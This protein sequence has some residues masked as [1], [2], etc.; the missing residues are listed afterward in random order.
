MRVDVVVVDRDGRPVTGLSAFDFDVSDEGRPREIVSFEPIVV[1]TPARPGQTEVATRFSQPMVPLIEGNR[2]FLIFFDDVHVH[3]ENTEPVRAQLTRFL[4][5]ETREGDWVTLMSPLA[6]LRFTARTAFE[7]SRLPVVISS[8]KGQLVRPVLGGPSDYSAMRTVEYGSPGELA[9][10]AE[11]GRYSTY[12]PSQSLLAAEAYGVAR[13]RIRRSLAGLSDAI[14]SL[15][16][17]RGRKSVLLYSEGFIKSPSMPDYD[18]VIDLARRT[19]VAIYYVDPRGVGRETIPSELDTASGGTTYLATATGGRVSASNDFAAPMRAAAL[20][21]S[22]YYLLGFQPAPGEPGE[23]K[24]KVRVRREGVEVRAPDRYLLGGPATLPKASPPALVAVGQIGDS[25]DIPL[26][27]AAL[28]SDASKNGEVATTVAVEVERTA[29]ETGER[30]LDLL[31]EARWAGSDRSMRDSAKVTVSGG[32]RPAVA[33][34]E[35]YLSP[36]LWQARVVVR[37]SRTEKL[38]SVLHTFEVPSATGLRISSPILSDEVKSELVPR[39]RL[40]LD[41]RYRS[42]AALYCQYRVFGATPDPATGKPRVTAGCAIAAGGRVV[43][44]TK[45]SPMEPTRDGQLLRLLGFG[46]AGFEPGGY[47]LTLRVFD[48]VSREA[49]EVAEPFTVIPAES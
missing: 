45:P 29:G 1:R 23:R 19:H 9:Q 11:H 12:T 7:R 34:R 17:F 15:A 24:L 48:E 2:Y 46:L 33:T 21:S 36:G 6:G 28:F 20:E 41:R 5:R 44:E 25:A 3:A 18:R 39:P 8:L 26:R 14:V 30:Q 40:Q 49:R 4:G 13:R 27:V 37:D 38:G 43:R 47:T 32:G 16:G 42:G 10:R 31:I 35:L 22:A